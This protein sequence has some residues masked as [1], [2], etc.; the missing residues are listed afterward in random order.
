MHVYVFLCI[1][2]RLYAN[3]VNHFNKYCNM[4]LLHDKVLLL[5]DCLL[6]MCNVESWIKA[7]VIFLSH[8]YYHQITPIPYH[9]RNQ[10]WFLILFHL[11]LFF[12]NHLGFNACQRLLFYD[13]WRRMQVV[14]ILKPCVKQLQKIWTAF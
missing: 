3:N 10:I 12:H 5:P 7:C 1:H 4:R 6:L 13:K 11:D 9:I 8:K 2:I 14:F